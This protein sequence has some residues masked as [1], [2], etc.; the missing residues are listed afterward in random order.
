MD[1]LGLKGC[2]YVDCREHSHRKYLVVN[3]KLL[4]QT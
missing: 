4:L 3:L 2:N 1:I